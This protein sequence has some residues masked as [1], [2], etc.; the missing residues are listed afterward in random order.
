MMIE[1][2]TVSKIRLFV[3]PVSPKWAYLTILTLLKWIDIES[4]ILVK[5]GKLKQIC[6]RSKANLISCCFYWAHRLSSYFEAWVV[7]VRMISPLCQPLLSY[8]QLV[9]SN[10]LLILLENW[11]GHIL[12]AEADWILALFPS[13]VSLIRQ[14]VPPVGTRRYLSS[15]D[16]MFC[17]TCKHL[18]PFVL[19][20]FVVQKM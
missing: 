12:P 11:A 5:F 2:C 9:R 18:M 10:L 6:F 15:L 4:E 3:F 19:A 17:N 13:M 14:V 7:Q 16:K 20:M 8:R 1:E